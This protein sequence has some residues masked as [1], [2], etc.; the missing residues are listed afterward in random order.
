M[1]KYVSVLDVAA[2]ILKQHGPMSTWKLQ[3]LC[4]YSQA[5]SLVWDEEPL[6]SEDIQAWAH[7]PVIPKL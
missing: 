6:F 2:S 3:K 5:W 7:G 1:G 4:Y